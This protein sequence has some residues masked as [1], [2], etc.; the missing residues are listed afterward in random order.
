MQ[1]K[2]GNDKEELG[3]KTFDVTDYDNPS[4]VSQG[5]AETH[6]Q[7]SDVYMSGNNEETFMRDGKDLVDGE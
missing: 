4:Q 2:P 5:L 7:V 1:S 3:S 6:E